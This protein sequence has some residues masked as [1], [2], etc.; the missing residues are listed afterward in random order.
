MSCSRCCH[1]LVQGCFSG[2]GAWHPH[3]RGRSLSAPPL[4]CRPCSD[5]VAGWPLVASGCSMAPPQRPPPGTC[6]AGQVR[7]V[8]PR[9]TPRCGPWSRRRRIGSAGGWSS[10]PLRWVGYVVLGAGGGDSPGASLLSWELC[11]PVSDPLSPPEFLQPGSTGS[12]GLLP[13]Q[14]V[15]RGV[16]WQEVKEGS[17]LWEGGGHWWHQGSS[18]SRDSAAGKVKASPGAGAGASA[19]RLFIS[20]E[21]F[22]RAVWEAVGLA[23]ARPPVTTSFLLQVLWR[24]RGGRPDR[25]AV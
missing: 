11:C 2:E 6:L 22:C 17:R 1:L 15:L 18:G 7:R 3:A 14:Q 8:W 16:P 9:A 25:A 19:G 24:S 4:L 5:V 21:V 12:P 20:T 23:G 13:Q 10:S